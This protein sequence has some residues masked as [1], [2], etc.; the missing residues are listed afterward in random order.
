MKHPELIIVQNDVFSEKPGMADLRS[1]LLALVQQTQHLCHWLLLT[2][3]PE[4]VA[5]MIE[6]AGSHSFSD[7]E[8]WFF[9]Y[10]N[11]WIGTV[12]ERLPLVPVFRYER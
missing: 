10:P 2:A 4:N 5:E 9:N 7:A 8:M 6:C 3:R 1:E 11:V 12:A